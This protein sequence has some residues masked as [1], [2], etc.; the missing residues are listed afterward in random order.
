MRGT[1]YAARLGVALVTGLVVAAC[2]AGG[3]APPDVSRQSGAAVPPGSDRPT[4]GGP[5][6][7]SCGSHYAEDYDPGVESRTVT[8]GPVSLVASRVSPVPADEPPVRMFKLA[9]RL[10]AGGEATLRTATTGT[11]LIYD[12]AAFREDNL[13]RLTDGEASVRFVGCGD[14]SAV[15]NGAILTAGPRTVDLVVMAGGAELP[16]TVTAYTG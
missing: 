8:A 1:P 7:R 3:Q 5:V 12:R 10:A 2:G 9:V 11:T 14:R 16:V 6:T 4:P 15:F 13:Y